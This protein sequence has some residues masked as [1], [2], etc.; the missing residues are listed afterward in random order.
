MRNLKGKSLGF[1]HLW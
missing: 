1:S